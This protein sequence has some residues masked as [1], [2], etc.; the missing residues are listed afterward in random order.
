MKYSAEISSKDLIIAYISKMPENSEIDAW[1]MSRATGVPPL[2]CSYILDRMVKEGALNVDGG[3]YS[4]NQ[5]RSDDV[6]QGE[7]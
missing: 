5:S 6:R 3:W 1:G 2:G 4:T 7:G